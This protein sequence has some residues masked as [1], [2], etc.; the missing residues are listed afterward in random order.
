[1]SE[2]KNV[3]IFASGNGTNALNILNYFKDDPE[4]NIK[5]LLVNKAD[6]PV[7]EKVKSFP[8][9]VIIFGREDL[10]EK[11]QIIKI[12]KK[13]EIHL[14]VLAGFLW[15]IPEALI[16][17][18]NGKIINIHPALLPK[19]GG[20]G[21]YGKNVHRAVAEAGETV[22]GITIHLVDEEFDR[23]EIIFRKE[24][25][26]APGEDSVSDIESKV[27]ELEIQFFPPVIEKFL[28]KS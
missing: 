19:F 7:I 5:L 26:L 21:M 13:N 27:R 6:A 3:A 15:K 28:K 14:I 2:T 10:Y 17:E 8:V 25:V 22:T 4:V 9:E 24:V 12:L 20:R 11:D 23:G 16:E 18:F 1:M